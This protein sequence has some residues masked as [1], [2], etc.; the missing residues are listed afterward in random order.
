MSRASSHQE[1][2][3]FQLDNLVRNRIP[4]VLLSLGVDFAKFYDEIV[5]Q[6]HLFSQTISTTRESILKDLSSRNIPSESAVVLVCPQGDVS[7][8][9]MSTLEKHGYSNVFL[10]RNGF[11]GLLKDRP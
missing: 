5:Y 6:N 3:F 1:I 2:G 11:Q 8:R 4:F 9:L 7:V 10:I